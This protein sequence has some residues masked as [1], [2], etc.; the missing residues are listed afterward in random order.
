MKHIS[1]DFRPCAQR[2]MQSNS[3]LNMNALKGQLESL[4]SDEFGPRSL[5]VG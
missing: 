2:G 4:L 3:I 1:F 5:V